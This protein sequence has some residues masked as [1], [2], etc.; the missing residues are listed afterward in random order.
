MIRWW[1]LLLWLW[2]PAVLAEEALVVV[3]PVCVEALKTYMAQ[4]PSW[5]LWSDANEKLQTLRRGEVVRLGDCSV[6]L[7]TMAWE[8]P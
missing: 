7:D 3:P 2:M 5:P 6:R 8:T 4:T 1:A